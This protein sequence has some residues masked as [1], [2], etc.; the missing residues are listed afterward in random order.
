[1]L[2][3]YTTS[4]GEGRQVQLLLAYTWWKWWWRQVGSLPCG[5]A[6]VWGP[7]MLPQPSSP[8]HIPFG[9]KSTSCRITA[10]GAQLGPPG[11]GKREFWFTWMPIKWMPTKCSPCAS[12]GVV[13]W[14]LLCP[15]SWYCYKPP[16]LHSMPCVQSCSAQAVLKAGISLWS[17][18]S[19]WKG[20]RWKALILLLG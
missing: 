7:E 14:G 6:V 18:S 3:N 4:V 16:S 15:T 20:S 5:Q 11:S 19:N 13:L 1:M 10:V 2:I 17:A 9:S 8:H 12:P